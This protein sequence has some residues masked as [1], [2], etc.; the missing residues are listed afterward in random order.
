MDPLQQI[1]VGAAANDGTGDSL[2]V[3]STKANENFTAI[4]AAVDAVEASV[5]NQWSGTKQLSGD[6]TFE[7]GVD[8]SPTHSIESPRSPERGPVEACISA[9]WCSSLVLLPV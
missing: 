8:G 1:N 5:E 4:E 3:A 6:L 9:S 7:A 2:R